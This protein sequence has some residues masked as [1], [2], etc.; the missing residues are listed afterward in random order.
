M[1][2]SDE[3]KKIKDI[4]HCFFSRNEGFSKGIYKSL[5]CGPGSKDSRNHISK[6]LN[7]ISQQMGVNKKSLILMNQTHSNDVVIVDE[8]NKKNLNFSCDALVSKIKGIALGVLTADCV[9]IILYDKRN[10]II[11]VI[12]SGWKGAFSGIIE[13]TINIFKS[14]GSKNEIY[15]TIGPCIGLSSYEV[16]EDFFKIFIKDNSKNKKYF[17]AKSDK[18]FNFNLR[19]YVENKLKESGIKSI[20]NV[21]FDTFKE[22]QNFFSYRRSVLKGDKDYGRCISTIVL[23]SD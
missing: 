6:N 17:I 8:K 14:L 7:F 23:N 5:N 11:G 2:Y 1:F 9:P 12:H 13:N 15:A 21:N 20:D 3:L 22:N 16:K 10:K 4:K 19:K 18:K